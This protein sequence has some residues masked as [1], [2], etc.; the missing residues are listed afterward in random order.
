LAGPAEDNFL[1]SLLLLSTKSYLRNRGIFFR[2]GAYF[3]PA[4]QP[5]MDSLQQ[6]LPDTRSAWLSPNRQVALDHMTWRREISPSQMKV[7]QVF[8]ESVHEESHDF[9]PAPIMC[10]TPAASVKATR[11]TP[12]FSAQRTT[13]SATGRTHN[14]L[15]LKLDA[16][17]SALKDRAD[18]FYITSSAIIAQY[19]IVSDTH[20]SRGQDMRA[21]APDE[22]QGGKGKSLRSEP[23]R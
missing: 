1:E 18:C 22:L 11:R 21:E 7:A 2:A 14:A 10:R 19:S 12:A 13:C 5:A 8:R 16:A 20:P 23:C 4:A 17:P 9:D 6:R 3:G 15:R